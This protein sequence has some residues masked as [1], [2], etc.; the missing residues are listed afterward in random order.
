MYNACVYYLDTYNMSP[1]V[2]CPPLSLALFK[3]VQW[4]ALQK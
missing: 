1:S 4:P 2:S 3:A